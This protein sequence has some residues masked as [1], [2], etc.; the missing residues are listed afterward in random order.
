MSDKIRV[1]LQPALVEVEADG[2]PKEIVLAIQ[3]VADYVDQYS[4]E[5]QGLDTGWYTLPLSSVSL[6]PQDRDEVRI[7]VHPRKE[8]GAKAGEYPYSLRVTSRAATGESAV[9]EGKLVIRGFAVYVA[10]ILPPTKAACL[11]KADF[12][13][14]I[15]NR[16]NVD[17]TLAPSVTDREEGCRFSL[18]PPEPTVPA[19]TP[20]PTAE[21]M[22][23]VRP[24]RSMWVGPQK[25]Y[26]VTLTLVPQSAK[27]EAKALGCQVLHRPLLPSWRPVF[28]WAKRAA[29][30][31]AVVALALL[32]M[33][34]V[35]REGGIGALPDTADRWVAQTRGSLQDALGIPRDQ[36]A[37]GQAGIGQA[38]KPA[39]TAGPATPTPAGR[40]FAEPFLPVFEAA[41]DRVGPAIEEAIADKDGNLHQS[42]ERGFLVWWKGPNTI[43]FFSKE[44]KAVFQYRNGG[45]NSLAKAE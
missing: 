6:F 13:V 16:G 20:P 29:A 40:A 24:K 22:L 30:V 25:Q 10:E 36:P 43:Y 27:G 19:G 18:Q 23:T 4:I 37:S 7:Q 31:I 11:R 39:P 28:S 32:G 9:V 42:T 14:R 1:S 17:V 44:E 5:L 12:R 2:E 33:Q 15:I 35:E 3:N 26:D 21:V 41:A 8:D 45:L 38:A 34:V